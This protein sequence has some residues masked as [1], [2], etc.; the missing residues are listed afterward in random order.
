MQVGLWATTWALR[1][2]LWVPTGLCR[3]DVRSG[4]GVNGKVRRW[5]GTG[6]LY[7]GS[8]LALS[9]A[10]AGVLLGIP[11]SLVA[12]TC[13]LL[14]VVPACYVYPVRGCGVSGFVVSA[15]TPG[16]GCAGSCWRG[17][18]SCRDTVCCC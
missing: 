1:G 13:A 3:G 6:F 8:M 11:S 15:V 9:M 14:G 4:A 2:Q 18:P 5:V 12:V 16:V 10:A 17:F 7:W